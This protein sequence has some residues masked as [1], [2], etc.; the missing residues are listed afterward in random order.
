MFKVIF[1][2]EVVCQ[3]IQHVPLFMSITFLPRKYC[4]ACKKSTLKILINHGFV[5]SFEDIHY[6]LLFRYIYGAQLMQWFCYSKHLHVNRNYR[7]NGTATS[8][9]PKCYSA[10][11]P[12]DFRTTADFE[13][14]YC[15]AKA[16]LAFWVIHNWFSRFCSQNG[17]LN[18]KLMLRWDGH[19]NIDVPRSE[20][21]S[22]SM[23]FRGFRMTLIF[24]HPCV[25]Y[26]VVAET[27][28][29]QK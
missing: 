26:V 27:R 22:P 7:P 5:T 28:R 19:F 13:M 16:L 6:I 4:V 15:L 10:N 24:V 8:L 17:Y 12:L 14:K 25:I 23:N 9:S 2:T 1:Y 11:V 3:K 20:I 18:S 21:F 29:G